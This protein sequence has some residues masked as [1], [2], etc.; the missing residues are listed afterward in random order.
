MQQMVIGGM[1][2]VY[3]IGKQFRNEGIDADHN[4]EFTT[5][6]FYQ[7]YGNLESLMNDTETLLSG[8]LIQSLMLSYEHGLTNIMIGLAQ[9]MQSRHGM[10]PENIRFDEPFKRIHVLDHLQA[11][12]KQPI[13]EILE[14]DGM[15]FLSMLSISQLLTN[16]P[17]NADASN[18]LTAICRDHGISMTGP[19]TTARILDKLISHYIEPECD[20][21]TFLY[22]HPL[23]LSPLAKDGV[24]EK[25]RSI[26]ANGLHNI[27]IHITRSR[28]DV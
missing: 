3:E 1:D 25:V 4:P 23:A 6:E 15:Q 2:R 19:P 24:D 27:H 20:Q 10:G 28:A 16:P 5:C 26:H 7:A 8:E 18:H 12:L 17:S 9:D 14:T 22:N 11:V 21:P 13:A